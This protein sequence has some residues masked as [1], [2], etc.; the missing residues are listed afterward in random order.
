MALFNTKK[1]SAKP[2]PKA[3]AAKASGTKALYAEENKQAESAEKKSGGVKRS[4]AYRVLL[5]PIVSEKASHQQAHNQYFFHVAVDANKI[6]VAKAVKDVYGIAPLKVN[7]IRVEGK[8]VSRG[9]QQ[10]R[11]KDWK[12]AVVTL[13]EGKTI[14]LY[15][16]V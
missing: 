15:E 2:A 14:S 5:R 13:P 4:N 10:G 8:T 11:R 7:M 1:T 12:K 16:G 9:R 6:E 3:T